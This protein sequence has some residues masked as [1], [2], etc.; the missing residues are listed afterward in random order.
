MA[1]RRLALVFPD[2]EGL[3]LAYRK[4]IAPLGA[5]VLASL[6]PPDYEVVFF[7]GRHMTIPHDLEADVV[8]I[9]AMT[10]QIPE[11]YRLA[12][13]F[14]KRKIPVVMGGAH[15]SLVP[16]EALAHADAVVVGEAEGLWGT[17]LEDVSAGRS[18]G[19]YVCLHKPSL[20][21]M[22][23]P[24]HD[25]L[26]SD[27]YLPIRSIQ[28]T[29]GCPLNCEFCAVPKNF[30][31]EYRV[32]PLDEV[33]GEI[34][35][36]SEYL[37]F[38]DDNLMIKRRM[39]RRL[40]ETMT[41]MD[42]RW[43]GMAPLSIASDRKYV[44]LLAR[45]GCWSMYVDVGPWISVGLKKDVSSLGEQVGKYLDYIA[46]L[47]DAGIKVMGSFIFGFDHDT[48]SIFDVTL[49]FLNKS[50]IVEAE[51]LILT[52]YPKT[53]LYEKLA[54]QGRIID[55]DWG[56]YNTRHAVFRPKQMAPEQLEE[57]VEYVWR[58]FYRRNSWVD[59]SLEV[60][61]PANET[62][63]KLMAAVPNL[64]RDQVQR[65]ILKTIRDRGEDVRRLSGDDLTDIWRHHDMPII[66]KIVEGA[67]TEGMLELDIDV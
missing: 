62:H 32:R 67:V 51:F 14:R 46:V 47:Q 25:L 19:A 40:F 2:F 55:E 31:R 39:F 10:P 65:A 11:A 8:A 20:S 64:F 42:R 27:D 23:Y 61:C 49:E 63:K 29:R 7:D 34:A 18:R 48:E 43:T 24:R 4:H 26:S 28:I 13:L 16:E 33:I 15:T 53:P 52:P 21:D 17:V 12:D 58:E 1:T 44:D 57:G 41:E 37:Y 60:D 22:P 35:S 54:L 56:R 36:L 45:S 59:H 38:V 6:T 3:P 9:S 30:G 5:L 50:G 66:W